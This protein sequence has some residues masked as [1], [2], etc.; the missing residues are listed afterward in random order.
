MEQSLHS[1]I[2]ISLS[3][4]SGHA[5][6]EVRCVNR[7]ALENHHDSST[8]SDKT[9]NPNLEPYAIKQAI[10]PMPVSIEKRV[11]VGWW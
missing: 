6:G 3:R 10:H 2:I 1:A 7:T 5:T 4:M 9:W 8:H 11:V